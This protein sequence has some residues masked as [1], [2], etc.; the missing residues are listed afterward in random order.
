MLD[1][2]I[3]GICVVLCGKLSYEMLLVVAGSD[4]R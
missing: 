2:F 3:G 4:F 1:V